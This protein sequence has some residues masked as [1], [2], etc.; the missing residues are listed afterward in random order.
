MSLLQP[1]M[2]EIPQEVIAAEHSQILPTT[3]QVENFR[4]SKSKYCAAYNT[5]V[6]LEE[7]AQKIFIETFNQTNVSIF[8]GGNGRIFYILNDVSIIV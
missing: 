4:E 1:S 3:L 8:Y 7:I 2:Y 5:M 6:Y